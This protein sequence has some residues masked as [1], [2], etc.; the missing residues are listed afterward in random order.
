MPEQTNRIC[1]ISAICMGISFRRPYV[2][3][4]HPYQHASEWLSGWAYFARAQNCALALSPMLAPCFGCR[5]VGSIL[6][7]HTFFHTHKQ[8]VPLFCLQDMREIFPW[9][10]FSLTV[11]ISSILSP[12]AISL[13]VNISSNLSP[14]K[15]G[16]VNCLPKVVQKTLGTTRIKSTFLGKEST[17]LGM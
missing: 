7:P 1:H 13:I 3:Y 10:T 12:C 17:A 11:C 4:G 6:S 16:G 15:D 2:L 9:R 14:C 5:D 8:N